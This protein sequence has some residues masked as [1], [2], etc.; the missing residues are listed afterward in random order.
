MYSIITHVVCF[1][2]GNSQASEFYMT[3]FR[4]I[5]YHLRG[6]VGVKNELGLRNVGVFIWEKI[7]LENSLSHWLRLFLSQ[8]ISHINTP[9]ISYK[10]FLLLTP[11][12]M[13][14]QTECSKMSA[15]KIQT[16]GDYPEE[17]IQHS[18][19]G[20]SLKSRIITHL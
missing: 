17:S 20:E 15:Y 4:N 16:P 5:L 18:E 6:Q 12:M 3:T 13:M 11:R 14:E 8:T 2:L 10:L 1:L 9:T 7:W 19:H